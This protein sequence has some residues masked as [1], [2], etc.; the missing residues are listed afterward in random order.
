MAAWSRSTS[1]PASQS[2]AP[3]PTRTARTRT[4][5]QQLGPSPSQIWRPDMRRHRLTI[6]ALATMLVVGGCAAQQPPQELISQPAIESLPVAGDAQRV[7]LAMPAF[8]DPTEITNPLFPV[9]SQASV[10]L[11]GTVEDL[12]FRTEVT[13]LPNP[14]I[15]EWQGMRVATLVSQYV[16]FLD[17]RIEEVAYDYYAQADDGSVWY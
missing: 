8:S 7:D 13:L 14:R 9:S 4:D 1:T 6:L 15:I 17:G 10:L 16:A 12:P 11:L 3:R 5:G 2:S